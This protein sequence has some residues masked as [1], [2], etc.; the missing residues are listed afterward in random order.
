MGTLMNYILLFYYNSKINNVDSW[1]LKFIKYL[2]YFRHFFHLWTSDI[3]FLIVFS[4]IN[5]DKKFNPQPKLLENVGNIRFTYISYCSH[6]NLKKV[7][8][9]SMFNYYYER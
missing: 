6:Q 4:S 8:H 7:E 5:V 2:Y 1:N 9:K 3:Y